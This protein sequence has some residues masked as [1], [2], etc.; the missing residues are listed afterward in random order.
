[1]VVTAA[2]G[3]GVV[4]ERRFFLGMALAL[5]AAAFIGFAPSY[6][7]AA[8]NDAPTPPL[9]PSIHIHG[10]LCTAW[11]LWLVLQASLVSVGRTDVHVITGAAGL[12][13]AAGALAS[14]LYVAINSERRVHT[15]ATAGTMADPYVF[16]IFPLTGITL[17]ALFVVL[18]VLN[19]SRPDVHK[20][21]ML[22]AT[23]SLISPALA[24]IVMRTTDIVAPAIG[25]LVLVN[26]FLVALVIYD[27]ATRG[28][29]HPT[30]FWVGGFFL[31][32]EPIRVMIGFSEPWQAFARTLM[33]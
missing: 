12:F 23:M 3:P 29:L 8:Y 5:A 25:A 26:V 1:M 10:A 6:Y 13:V 9:T 7:L 2:A 28:R 31:I 21:L 18:A 4:S 14:G 15:E 27:L 11:V 20:R 24:R 33:G 32:S 16:L 17:F 30:T 22:L 19:R